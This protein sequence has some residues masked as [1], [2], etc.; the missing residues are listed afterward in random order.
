M[1]YYFLCRLFNLRCE[2]QENSR[3]ELNIHL[4]NMERCLI[5]IEAEEPLTP[6]LIY[7]RDQGQRIRH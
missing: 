1:V 4:N 3:A 7:M 2:T 6:A 5:L